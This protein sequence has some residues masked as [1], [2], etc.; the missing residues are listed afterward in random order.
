[1]VR[2]APGELP[3]DERSRDHAIVHQVRAFA[4]L[5]K[6]RKVAS[7]VLRQGRWDVRHEGRVAVDRVLEEGLVLVVEPRVK[8]A[9]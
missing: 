6:K 2:E 8:V 5:K 3:K 7:L 9:A 1:V 4:L